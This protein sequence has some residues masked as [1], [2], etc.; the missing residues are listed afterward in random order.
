LLQLTGAI[1]KELEGRFSLVVDGVPFEPYRGY[2][3]QLFNSA[4]SS[5]KYV[6]GKLQ[7]LFSPEK[8][9]ELATSISGRLE[10]SAMSLAF[11]EKEKPFLTTERLGV[12]LRTIQLGSQPRVDI[13]RIAF[14]G[15]NLTVLRSND[16]TL[17]V[18]RLWGS[19]QEE[20]S[21]APEQ[22][23]ESATTVAIRSITVEKSMIEIFD[24]SVSP[25]YTTTVADL[26]GKLSNLVPSA[27]RAELE[28]KGIL[29]KSANLVLSGWFTPFTEK[30]FMHLEGTVRSYALPPLNPYATEYINHRIRQGEITTDVNYTL[31]GDEIQATAELVL[32]DVRIGEKTGDECASR[33]GIPL[34]LAIALLQ[35]I[36]GV[37]RLQVGMSA[38]TGPQLDIGNVIWNA[39]QNAIVR[40][41]T[42]PFRLVGRILTFGGRIGQIRIEPLLFQPGTPELQSESVKQLAD[43]A[44]LLKDK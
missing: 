41:I 5:G 1:G 38:G 43:L 23:S 27:K 11:P 12:D 39:V 42:A 44:E 35:D 7:V 26:K 33:I 34:E 17:N 40:A 36:N 6:D 30:P 15:A 16:G 31:K 25:N 9:G 14:L 32:R 3:D 8:G 19:D 21:P 29:G 20:P 24:T 22:E 13:D 18:T 10:G 37:I 4:K 2:L 28:L